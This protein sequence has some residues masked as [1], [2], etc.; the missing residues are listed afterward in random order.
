[1]AR[2][3]W[4]DPDRFPHKTE[5]QCLA[6]LLVKVTRHEIDGA[7]REYYWTEWYRGL[8]QIKSKNTPA[9][10]VVSAGRRAA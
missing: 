2:H 4:G 10:E 6:C 1:M 7:G 8:D 9:C 3:I 5:R